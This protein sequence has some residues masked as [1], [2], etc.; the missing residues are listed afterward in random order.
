VRSTFLRAVPLDDPL[1]GAGEL[2]AVERVVRAAFGNRRKTLVNALRGAALAPPA[3]LQAVLEELDIDPRSRAER[4]TPAQF[5]ALTR[6]LGRGP[7]GAPR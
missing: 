7:E 2:P 5:L 6:A 4:L 1:L 3:Q